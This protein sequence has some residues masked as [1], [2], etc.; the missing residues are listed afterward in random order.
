[1]LHKPIHVQ[2]VVGGVEPGVEH[3]QVYQY[4]L[5]GL[6]D[7][8]LVLSSRPVA[9]VGSQGVHLP[10]P[11]HRV[12]DHKEQRRQAQHDLLL[13]VLKPELVLGERVAVLEEAPHDE[14]GG[15]VSQPHEQERPAELG[16]VGDGQHA[17]EGILNGGHVG[18]TL[19]SQQLDDSLLHSYI[20]HSK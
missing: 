1:M 13:G 17:D 19:A 6:K 14:V 11:D 9:V 4:L 3:H 10:Q 16:E 15:V 18:Q 8:K 20:R 12:Q 7:S 2:Q 5:Q